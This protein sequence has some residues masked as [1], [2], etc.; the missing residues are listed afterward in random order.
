MDCP[1]EFN[2]MVH[3]IWRYFDFIDSKSVAIE[4]LYLNC[5]EF[6]DLERVNSRT[7]V[8]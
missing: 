5:L 6:L 3:N 8:V 1:Q 7:F 4:D 2:L